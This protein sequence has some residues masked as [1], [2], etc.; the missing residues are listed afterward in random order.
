MTRTTVVGVAAAVVVVGGGGF[1]VSA[2]VVAV[3]VAVGCEMCGKNMNGQTA[4]T[5][6]PIA[7]FFV[8]AFVAT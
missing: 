3:V 1:V 2:V 4:T 7:L 5:A 6:L 8:A